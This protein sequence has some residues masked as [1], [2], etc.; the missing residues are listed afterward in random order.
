MELI[1]IT[2]L[3][4]ISGDFVIRIN[5]ALSHSISLFFP[6]KMVQAKDSNCREYCHSP[7]SRLTPNRILNYTKEL[8]GLMINFVI[9]DTNIQMLASSCSVRNIKLQ[10]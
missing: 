9:P 2:Y 4:P 3:T 5:L 1:A 8:K 6:T 7:L 10:W